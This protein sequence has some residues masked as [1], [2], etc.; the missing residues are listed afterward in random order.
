MKQ[1]S[2][3]SIRARLAS[4]AVRGLFKQVLHP[5]VPLAWQ[6]RYT[7]AMKYTLVRPR[8][9]GIRHLIAGGI[10]YEEL[11]PAIQREH[12]GRVVVYWHGGGYA[13]GSPGLVRSITMRLAKLS[14]LRVY[15][16]SYRLAPEHPYPAQLQDG[17]AFLQAV[18]GKEIA[19]DRTIFAGDSAGGNLALALTLARRKAGLA[20]PQ[21]LALIS[22]WVDVLA[23]HDDARHADAMLCAAWAK[24]LLDAYLPS[25]LRSRYESLTTA[26]LS[27]L[28]PVMIQY[29]T[30][31]MLAPDAIL[32]ERRLHE[33]GVAVTFD[34]VPGMWHDFQLHAG[35]VPEADEALGRLAKF[36]REL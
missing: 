18:E 10:R 6:R 36:L 20:L 33:A 23:R 26:D 15:V 28:P 4:M 27:G 21:G 5:T 32:L 12:D 3:M 11:L 25:A 24:Q 19:I 31:E 13:I 7:E 9:V 34:A 17:M 16:P 35:V 8:G 29:A 1:P 2:T 14:G 22:P 30:S